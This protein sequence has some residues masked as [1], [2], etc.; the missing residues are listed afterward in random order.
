VS[1]HSACI[2]SAYLGSDGG[3][4]SLAGRKGVDASS[5]VAHNRIPALQQRRLLQRGSLSQAMEAGSS[6]EYEGPASPKSSLSQ[7]ETLSV[8]EGHTSGVQ[9]RKQ[10]GLIALAERTPAAEAEA[11]AHGPLRAHLEGRRRVLHIRHA[12]PFLTQ[13]AQSISLLPARLLH[14]HTSGELA[15]AAALVRCGGPCTCSWR[16]GRCAW[17]SSTAR[18]PG[19][20]RM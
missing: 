18:P 11:L 19:T 17:C 8:S 7:F 5:L 16:R 1:L 12:P 20:C 14:S 2:P 9:E 15:R 3:A 10:L 6:A 13:H 4:A